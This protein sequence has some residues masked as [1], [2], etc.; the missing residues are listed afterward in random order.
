MAKRGKNNKEQDDENKN[1]ENISEAEVKTEKTGG[2]VQEI[3]VVKELIGMVIYIAFVVL[4]CWFIITFVGQRT[5]VSGE[6]MYDTLDDG[7]NL[8]INKFTYRFKDPERFDIVVFPPYE[9]EEYYIKRVIGLPGE[10]VRIDES[11]IIYINDEPLEEDYGY[12]KI[13]SYS[14]GRADQDIILGDD[15]YFVMGDNRNNSLDSRFYEVGNVKR[16]AFVGKAVLRLWPLS[17]FGKIEK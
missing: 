14:I 13:D 8:W 15:E 9:G 5:V 10:K 1:M 3:N 7:D 4:I 2:D 12:E 6:S 16:D 11:G 17:K